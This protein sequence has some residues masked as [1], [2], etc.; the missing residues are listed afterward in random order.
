[1][2]EEFT[3]YLEADDWKNSAAIIGLIR[4]FDFAQ[5]SYNK[6]E[7]LNAKEEYDDDS[8][9][10]DG[11]DI[12]K[13]NSADI[14]YEKKIKFIES[15]FNEDMHHLYVENVLDRM[16][17]SED[18]IVEIN[19][20]LNAN[21]VMKKFFKDLKFDG[22]N[23]YEILEVIKENR[24][25]IV[26][27]TYKNKKYKLFCNEKKLNLHQPKK[28]PTIRL[29]G[30]YIDFTK[31]GRS[32]SFHFNDKLFQSSDSVYYD[33]IPFAFTI[34]EESF[35][36]NDNSSI[37]QLYET[38][39]KLWERCEEQKEKNP[40]KKG[41]TRQNLFEGI[42]YS[43]GFIDF[44]VEIIK[45][46][47]NK[48]YFETLYLRRESI[49]I[50]KQ[51]KNYKIFC[52]SIKVKNRKDPIEIQN[53]VT[54]AVSNLQLMDNLINMLLKIKNDADDERRGYTILT[55]SIIRLNA[56]IRRNI[57]NGGDT[58]NKAMKSAYKGAMTAVDELKKRN[59][60]NK[61]Q[62]YRAKLLSA[63]L[64]QDYDRFSEILL[65]LSNFANVYFPFA[66]DLFED[67]EANKEVAYTFVNC[68][69]EYPRS[70]N[71]AE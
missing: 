15:Y 50:F 10:S 4:F 57:Y 35:F 23:V 44:D 28:N 42:I 20:K 30:Y 19:K 31:K 51:I 9:Y 38:N 6:D 70:Q 64:L 58:M 49:K 40:Y 47:S 16:E 61:I 36:I 3:D 67:F 63:L 27:E 62:S 5:I 69:N 65:N 59:Q 24:E 54:D 60:K 25:T 21:A 13:F 55:G 29:K 34:G 1:M 22:K 14:T 37:K 71:D 11:L 53:E 46:D 45:K 8:G 17:W 7:I 2:T 26:V 12:L 48:E 68:F 52:Q 41:Y 56:L 66:Y 33:F 32:V 18:E 43:S 39:Q